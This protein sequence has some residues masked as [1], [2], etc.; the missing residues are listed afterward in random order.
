MDADNA[1]VQL[2]GEGMMA[3]GSGDPE[4]ARKL[5]QQA[6]NR[7]ADDFEASTAAHYLARHQ[8]TPA[9]TLD[10]NERSLAH[11]EAAAAAGDERVRGFFPSLHLNLG[12]SHEDLGDAERAR[13]HYARA[14]QC[15]DLLDDDGYGSLVRR[16]VAAGL[17]RVG[18]S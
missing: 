5:F 16:G 14:E 10:W 1:V 18:A 6:W 9:A 4:T 8:P 3:E 11:A 2:C 12:R 7:R 15:L 13:E 17:E